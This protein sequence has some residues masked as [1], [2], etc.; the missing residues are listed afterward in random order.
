MDNHDVDRIAAWL[1]ES[2]LRGETELTLLN[3]FCERCR[4]IGIAVSRAIVII[5]TLHPIYEGRGFRW[6]EDETDEAPLL[7][8]KRDID[9]A[10]TEGWQNS[11]FYHLI[12]RGG[13]ELRCKLHAGETAGFQAIEELRVEGQTDYFAKVHLFAPDAII[14]EM[15][16]LASRWTTAQPGGFS[17]AEITALQH[18]TPILG[19]AIKSASLARV[20]VAVV[21][22]YLGRDAGR[23]VLAGRMSRGITEKMN[24]VLWFSDMRGYTTL[25]ETIASDQLIPLLNDYAEA[26]ISAVHGAGGN[27]L[28]L[29]GD[30]TLAIFTDADPAAACLS[31]MR[32]E[33]D[34]R[35]RLAELNTRRAAAGEPVSTIYLGL[36][37]GDVFYG[38]IGSEDR[39]DFTVVGQAVNEVS[40]IA[41]MC[42]SADRNVLFSTAFREALPQDEKA[43]LVCVGRYALRGVGRAQELFTLDPELVARQT[44]G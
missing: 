27:V 37:I 19:L 11:P 42:R 41:S 1:A 24:A 43:K 26:V 23:R 7:E 8:F 33:A 4:A 12:Q 34:L 31:A 38:N 35:Q 21:E 36:H 30:G 18:L 28:K 6:R 29:M 40:R 25:S 20:P 22:A 9:G 14:G 16:N 15:D 10:Q 5:D 3:G 17:D 32:A 44:I 13:G 2:G 39:L